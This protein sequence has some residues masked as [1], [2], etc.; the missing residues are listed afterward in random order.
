[1]VEDLLDELRR[2]GQ[3]ATTARRAVLEV[4]VAA[5]DGHLSADE[6]TRRVRADHP[7][8]HLSTIYRT[9]EALAEAGL[10]TPA[11]FADQPTTYHLRADVHH[12]A[13]CTDCGATI[14]LPPSVL[15]SLRRSLL[16][17]HGFHADPHHLT[18][19]GRCRSCSGA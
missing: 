14:N 19:T 18:I 1:M 13:V 7:A 3:R 2:S 10:L 6:L 9:L 17:D 11:P 4:L 15:A 16:A 8:I 5:G 12:H